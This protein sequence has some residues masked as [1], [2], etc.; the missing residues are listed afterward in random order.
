MKQRHG[1]LLQNKINILGLQSFLV[2][3]FVLLEKGC[4][5][6]QISRLL[7]FIA[8]ICNQAYAGPCQYFYVSAA[9]GI[10]QGDF[11]TTFV[12]Q[13]DL[14]PQNI[15][16]LMI[17]HAY[18]GELALG[19]RW[20]YSPTYFIGSEIS[21]STEGHYAS[22]QSGAAS[23]AF[24][25]KIQIQ[26]LMDLSFTPGLLLS[27]NT[28]ASLKIGISAARLRDYITTPVGFVP[29]VMSYSWKNNYKLA[30]RMGLNIE[31]ALTSQLSIFTEANYR[32]FGSV[33]FLSFQ[34]FTATYSHSS[35]IYSYDVLLGLSYK[36]I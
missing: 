36:F 5:M 12:D 14:I 26:N 21:L 13:T 29:T 34:N 23:S 17:Q 3:N 11:I 9:T 24:S 35:H 33:N 8:C 31:R 25:D 7:F 16:Q 15:V 28:A 32:D 2:Y 6:K 18:L 20:L 4:S 1:L 10:F 30:F 27:T 19:Y 22:F